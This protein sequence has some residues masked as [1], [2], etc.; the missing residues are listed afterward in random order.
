MPYQGDTTSGQQES[1]RLP[2][3]VRLWRFHLMLLH[4]SCARNQ[5]TQVHW[6]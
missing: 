1:V 6:N 3:R 4:R 5:P 2:E